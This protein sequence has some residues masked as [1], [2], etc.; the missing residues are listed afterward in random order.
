MANDTPTLL[1]KV[2]MSL[3]I[4]S[5]A[6]NAELNTLIDACKLDLKVA[7]IE[8]ETPDV[9]Q[10]VAIITYCRARFGSPD[11]YERVKKSYD[12]QKAQMLSSSLYVL[13]E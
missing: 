1:D 10:E 12:E 9:L 8:F 2:K 13:S 6:Y 3:R 5:D 11:D 4:T 7:G